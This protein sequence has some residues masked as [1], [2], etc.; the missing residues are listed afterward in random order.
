[1]TKLKKSNHPLLS[2]EKLDIKR[3]I[4]EF[5][6]ESKTVYVADEVDAKYCKNH[7]S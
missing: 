6:E 1:M 5:L 2:D 7:K 3:M 4:E